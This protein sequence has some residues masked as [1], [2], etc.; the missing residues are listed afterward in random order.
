MALIHAYRSRGLTRDITVQ[1]AAGATIA[2]GTNDKI[3]ARIGRLGAAALFSVESG[4]DTANGSSFQ[5]N[6]NADHENRLRLDAAD[7]ALLDAGVYTLYVDLFDNAD[8]EEWKTI[9]RQCFSLE[10]S[11]V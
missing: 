9:S 1:D 4:T 3:R 7:L 2:V 8:S 11:D 6:F 5:K 10:D